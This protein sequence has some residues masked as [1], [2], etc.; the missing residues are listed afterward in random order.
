ML[1]GLERKYKIISPTDYLERL[2]R[3]CSDKDCIFLSFDG[4]LKSQVEIAYPILKERGLTA[5]W[6]PYTNVLQGEIAPI[7][8]YHHFKFFCYKDVN[9]FYEEF[10]E[11]FANYVGKD[12][13]ERILEEAKKS[14]Q[15]EWGSFYTIND[16]MH[17]YLRDE[18]LSPD[19]MDRLMTELMQR[20]NYCSKKFYDQLW[21]NK[22]DI[23]M[24]SDEGHIIGS[25]SHTHPFGLAKLP[26]KQQFYEYSESKKVLESLLNKTI[27]CV[28]Y[29]ANS[30][31]EVTID[32]VKR[33][34]FLYG[35]TAKRGGKSQYEIPRIDHATLLRGGI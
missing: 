19:E 30:Y 26:A 22:E 7:E 20:H 15:Y 6:F 1:D 11:S 32:E 3:G 12:R 34:G 18:I 17:K 8:I 14:L 35:F 4:G 16:K 13:A 2:K 33:A 29:P 24:L 31:S 10:L 27:Q 21:L 23:K 9:V 28:T 25:H 5:F